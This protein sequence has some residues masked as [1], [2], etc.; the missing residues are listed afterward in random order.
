MTVVQGAGTTNQTFIFMKKFVFCAA[1]FAAISFAACSDD[2]DESNLPVT[3]ANI[4][5]TWKIVHEQGYEDDGYEIE[6]WSDDYPCTDEDVWWYWTFT[7]DEGGTCTQKEIDII[8]KVESSSGSDKFSYSISGNT[9][10]LSNEDEGGDDIVRYR[11]DKLTKSQ[12]VLFES[13]DDGYY[14]HLENTMTFKR[15]K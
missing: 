12:L 3:E 6:T 9:L 1:L 8:D 4:V 7:F 15:I 13:Q 5:G 14:S 11:I 2:D 10:T